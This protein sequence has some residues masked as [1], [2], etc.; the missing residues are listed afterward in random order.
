MT[1]AAFVEFLG[2]HGLTGV[3]GGRTIEQLGRQ[4]GV[5]RWYNFI[6]AIYLPP[7]PLFSENESATIFRSILRRRWCRRPSFVATSISQGKG[8]KII[9]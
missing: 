8:S 4:Y 7:S 5:R 6:E 2:E 3:D 9:S 1:Q